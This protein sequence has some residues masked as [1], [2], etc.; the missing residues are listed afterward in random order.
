M[1]ATIAIDATVSSAP[2]DAAS[3][4]RIIALDGLRG[5]ACLAV[6][7][8]HYIGEPEVRLLAQGWAG[9]ILFFVLSG[10]LIGGI[11]LDNRD[12]PT[13]F[14]TFYRRRSV[15]IFPV[16]YVVIVLILI[17]VA[18]FPFAEPS[19][20]SPVAYL[21]FTF[22]IFMGVVGNQGDLWL[23]PTW[24]LCVE[25]QF[26]LLLPLIIFVIPRSWPLGKVFL[27]LI[28]SVILFRG[29]LIVSGAHILAIRALLPS[30]VDAL[31]IGVLCA[32]VYRT[33]NLWLLFTRNNC[34]WLRNIIWASLVLLPLLLMIQI[35]TGADLWDFLGWTVAAA[36]AGGVLMLV[37]ADAPEAKRFRSRALCSLGRISYCLYLIHQP[38]NGILH[39]LL[40]GG[41]PDFV[42]LPQIAVTLLAAVTSVALATLSWLYFERPILRYG[43]RWQYA[44]PAGGEG[45]GSMAGRRD[46]LLTAANG[47]PT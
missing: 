12:S 3:D 30:R 14:K 4:G 2:A 21:T 1:N 39:G 40:L 46:A 41:R 34:Y 36:V 8:A 31:F 13:Y 35:D 16:Y 7:V 42:T 23:L 37:V 15:R 47:R 29:V 10:F 26:Y 24:T 9:V 17:A 27:A 5:L 44:K 28:V 45:R 38:I 43:R 19:P 22:N 25:E 6:I 33:P 11:L 32:Y 18:V 20:Y